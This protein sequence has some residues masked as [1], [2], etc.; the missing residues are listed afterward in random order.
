VKGTEDVVHYLPVIVGASGG[1][2]VEAYPHLLPRALE[3]GVVLVD[4]L[5]RRKS[6]LLSPN[7]YRCAML[8]ASRYHQ[9]LVPLD[10]VVSGEDVSG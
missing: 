7:G 9:H 1:K 2:Q 10:A 4:H 5:L 3:L 6:F 8:I